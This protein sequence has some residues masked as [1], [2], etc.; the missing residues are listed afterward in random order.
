MFTA[1]TRSYPHHHQPYT[2][3]VKRGRPLSIEN[4]ARINV[5]DEDGKQTKIIA[6]ELRGRKD[7]QK[8][9][10]PPRLHAKKLG[11]ITKNYKMSPN[12]H[13]VLICN[14]EYIHFDV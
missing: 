13:L 2:T 4:R 11:K 12:I 7:A 14:S 8:D 3:K 10:S 9:I 6:N 5:L 1:R